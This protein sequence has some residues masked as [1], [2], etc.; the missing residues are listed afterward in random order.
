M[1]KLIFLYIRLGSNVEMSI[2]FIQ[3]KL[4]DV[5]LSQHGLNRLTFQFIGNNANGFD[6]VLVGYKL[7]VN[8][9]YTVVLK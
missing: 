6:K 2:H 4:M 1:I 7:K 9:T 5:H 8:L 3:L